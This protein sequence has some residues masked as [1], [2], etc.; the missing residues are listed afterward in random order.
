MNDWKRQ[1]EKLRGQLEDAARREAALR[2]SI[3]VLKARVSTLESY[4]A[5]RDEM[6]RRYEVGAA[7][8]RSREQEAAPAEPQ[9]TEGG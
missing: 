6:L 9:A 7:W 5:D 3:A 1:T 2:E 4:L 8:E